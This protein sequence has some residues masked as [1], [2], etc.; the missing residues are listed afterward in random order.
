MHQKLPI[1]IDPF[2]LAK[3]GLTLDGKLPLSRMPRLS[4]LITDSHGEVDVKMH[5]DIDKILGTSI[6]SGEFN[7]SLP[8]ICERCSESMVFD[9]RVKCLLA[10][11][12]SERKI[13]GLAEQYEPWIINSD[14]P[15]LLSSIVEDELILAIPLVPKHLHACLPEEAWF[16][17]DEQ[18]SGGDEEKPTSPFAALA[19][20]KLKD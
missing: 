16:S 10:I 13:E 6:M 8:L 17:G 2:R 11:V 7:A 20:L 4:G 3:G 14:D 9:A 19:A 12:N 1:E 5:F 18:E 15:I